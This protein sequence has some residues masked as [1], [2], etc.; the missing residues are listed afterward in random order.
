MNPSFWNNTLIDA[1]LPKGTPAI[2]ASVNGYISMWVRLPFVISNGVSLLSPPGA[3]SLGW[4]SIEWTCQRSHR[5]NSVLEWAIDRWFVDE[6]RHRVCAN[7]CLNRG[8]ILPSLSSSLSLYLSGSHR[9][10]ACELVRACV[11]V[12]VCPR[13]Q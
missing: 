11:C 2:V 10:R 8:C 12:F 9:V 6:K 3:G 13:Q 1:V 7:R 4:M 5:T